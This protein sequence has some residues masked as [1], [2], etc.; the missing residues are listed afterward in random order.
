MRPGLIGALLLAGVWAAAQGTEGQRV[1]YRCEAVYLPARS[2]WVRELDLLH[3]GRTL[4]AVW[5]DGAPVHRFAVSGT[6]LRTALD[7]ERIVFD[8]ASLAWQSDLRGVASAHG[9]CER[10]D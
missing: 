9:R 10:V 2:T 5:I 4:R 1:R 6:T 8:T 3:D 7:N